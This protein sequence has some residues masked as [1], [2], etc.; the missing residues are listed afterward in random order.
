M[1]NIA[2]FASGT[3][4]N[5]RCLAD[6]FA[7]SSCARVRLIVSNKP[8]APVLSIARERHIPTHVIDRIS[9]YESE[10]LLTV[11]NEYKIGFIA[12]AGFLWL[13]P[14][15]LVRTYWQRMVNIHPA[16]LPAY[17]GKG[18][19]GMR[20]HEAVKAAGERETGITIHYVNERYDEG[21]IIFQARC[22]ISSEDSPEEI[23][24]KVQALEHEHY[25]KVLER[26]ICPKT[27]LRL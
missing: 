25:P 2:V 3:G 26:L 22:Y 4:S 15:Y 23:A 1:T 18:M 14:P 6:Y 17:G 7:H 5:A 21:D 8:D 13:V 19:Y 24:R 20:V 10:Q 27:E 16:L 9:F 12:L 11:L